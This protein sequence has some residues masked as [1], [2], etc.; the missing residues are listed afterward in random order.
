MPD[1]PMTGPSVDSAAVS[2]QLSEI[3]ARV[4]AA[5]AA[6]A[7]ADTPEPV[8]APVPEPVADVPEVGIPDPQP[9]VA[10]TPA[11]TPSLGSPQYSE[12]AQALLQQ[13]GGDVNKLA[14]RY[15]ELARN[16][17][18]AQRPKPVEPQPTAP[19]VSAQ[20]QQ[21]DSRLSALNG[22]FERLDAEFGQVLTKESALEAERAE[23]IRA[24]INPDPDTD[25]S[26][27]TK[28]L[29]TI[30]SNLGRV[31]KRK[32]EITARG[33]QINE[34]RQTLQLIKDQALVNEQLYQA[35]EA[36]ER[37]AYEAQV[38]STRSEFDIALEGAGS[39]ISESLREDFFEYARARTLRYLQS[40]EKPVI[41]DF[42][43]HTAQM[44]KD[45]RSTLDKHHRALAAEYSMK[46]QQDAAGSAPK[47]PNAVAP[48]TTKPVTP[49]DWD[50]LHET[51][52]F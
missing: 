34:N 43:A 48:M 16:A 42:K 33:T 13:H 52:T 30:E 36:Q 24:L 11:P 32:A 1:Q 38:S 20:I 15:Y 29:R 37:G 5:M 8:S 7:Q 6:D 14:E 12:A 2:Q 17:E 40:P 3:D 39:Q 46:K 22:E 35:R 41:Q 49:K 18:L 21:F 4:D 23:A 45:F 25:I 10:A 26:V 28:Q 19:V 50:A 47:G 9:V 31:S 27:L 51:A 44:A